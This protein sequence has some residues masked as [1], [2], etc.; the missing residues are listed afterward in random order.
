MSVTKA[1]ARPAEPGSGPRLGVPEI[2]GRKGGVP[3]VMLTA[4]TAPTARL[5]D[6]HVDVLLVGD[7][8]GMVVY[9]LESTL[10][11]TVDM[12]IAH[13][14]AVVRGSRRASSSSICRSAPTR[15]ARPRPSAPP[16]ACSPRRVR[17]PSSSRAGGR[18]PRRSGSSPSAACR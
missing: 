18:W 7:S 17:R 8:L 15:R 10:A 12:M 14:A 11:V 4:Y 3:V 16:R 9:G 13:G 6:P 2:A 5:L 1:G